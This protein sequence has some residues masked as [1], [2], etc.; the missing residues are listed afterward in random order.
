MNAETI[1]TNGI[2]PAGTKRPFQIKRLI[3][4]ASLNLEIPATIERQSHNSSE[5]PREFPISALNPVMRRIVEETAETFEIVPQLPGMAAL[6]TL[7]GAAGKGWIGVGASNKGATWCNLMVVP[8]V[9][10][11]YGKGVTSVIAEPLIE[12]SEEMTKSFQ[13]NQRP[14]LESELL[15]IEA[16]IKTLTDRLNPHRRL[17]TTETRP[18]ESEKE[19]MRE[20]RNALKQRHGEISLLLK[21]TPTYWIGGTSMAGMVEAL[22]RNNEAIFH[23]SAEAGEPVRIALGKHTKDQAADFDL[24][25]SGYSVERTGNT[26][27][28][29]GDH[30]LTPCIS[31]LW[32]VQ[33]F[34]LHELIVNEE[35]LERGLTARMLP[36]VFEPERIAEDDGKIR[37][38]TDAAKSDWRNLVRAIL[39]ARHMNT[40]PEE[41]AWSSDAREIFREFHNESVRLRNGKWHEM[42]GELGRW[43]E[44]AIRIGNGIVLA[45]AFTGHGAVQTGTAE[46][47]RRAVTLMRW[48]ARSQLA[49]FNRVREQRQLDRLEKLL[50]LIQKHGGRIT[51]RDLGLRHGFQ[52]DQ[53]RSLAADYRERLQIVEESNA[54]GGRPSIV[55]TGQKAPL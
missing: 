36:F 10:K 1:G 48:C 27:I 24:L 16:E 14:G 55:I 9:P 12:A 21:S 31:L 50:T 42:E 15:D 6:A 47:A 43:R 34:L 32:M 35:A 3:R 17:R 11:S 40:G 53:V 46:Q 37:Y 39:E 41:I 18:S 5:D 38:V 13:R 7:A 33:P 25:L 54:N 45:D 2:Q 30:R 22:A 49:V 23:Y 4:K 52:P 44:N 26:T 8:A 28:S 51:L 20:R 19:G 29:R